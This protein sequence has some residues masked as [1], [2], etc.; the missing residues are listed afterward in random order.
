MDAPCLLP[1]HGTSHWPNRWHL[2]C[3]GIV[4]RQSIGAVTKDFTIQDE[5][6]NKKSHGRLSVCDDGFS[7]DEHDDYAETIGLFAKQRFGI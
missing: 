4:W 3:M 6:W 5:S 1:W 7:V 2:S